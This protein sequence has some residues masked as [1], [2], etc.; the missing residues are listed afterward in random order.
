MRALMASLAAG[1]FLA[2]LPALAQPQPEPAPPPPDPPPGAEPVQ[3]PGAEPPPPPATPP[4]PPP[5]T[6]PPPPGTAPPPPA[7][8]PPPGAP[9][10]PTPG[11]G[12]GYGYPPPPQPVE[13]PPPPEP[14]ETG[15][16]RHDGF[17]LRLGI[18]LAYG[19]VVSKGEIG[20]SEIEATFDGMGPAYEL[21]IG[22]TLGSGFV[23]GG[24]FV[25]QD[26]SEPNV[27]LETG[28]TSVD[29]SVANDEALGIGLLG[30]F[31]DWFPD[32]HG[33]GHVGAMLGLGVVGLEGDDDEA[34]TGF[35]AALFGGYD[36]FISDQ[37]S[38]GAELRLLRVQGKRDVLGESFEESATGAQL[39]FTAL[40]H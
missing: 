1:V 12:Y 5:G 28:G 19:N 31:V 26:I 16:R 36:F 9:P 15:A 10:P 3:P 30:V 18:G 11:Y 32:E 25:G 14:P 8:Q 2:A 22:G 17:Y 20:S 24:G 38:L 33:G 40:L 13:P 37:W 7:G 21:M 34:S 4:P 39:L 29:T 27:E 6:A 35:G 23:L